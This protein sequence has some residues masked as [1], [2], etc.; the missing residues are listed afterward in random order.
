MD[1]KDNKILNEKL[2]KE[3]KENNL[4][5][6]SLSDKELSEVAG[7]KLSNVGSILHTTI[8]IIRK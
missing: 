8:D 6:K 7:G 3:T 4:Q 2:E 5:D 1:N